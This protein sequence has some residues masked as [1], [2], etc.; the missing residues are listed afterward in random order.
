MLDKRFLR[1]PRG[2]G[3]GGIFKID[4]P[5]G[6]VGASIR[7]TEKPCGRT[8]PEGLDTGD[9]REACRRRDLVLG[10]I[11]EEERCAGADFRL[12][13]ETALERARARASTW[14][15]VTRPAAG[16]PCRSRGW[17]YRHPLQAA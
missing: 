1:Q 5:Q 13:E 16:N 4:A 8:I 14:R 11:R 3:T 10:H 2:T 15:A 7:R 9:V 6:L 12:S 17:I